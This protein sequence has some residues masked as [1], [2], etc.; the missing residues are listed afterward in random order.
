VPWLAIILIAVLVGLVVAIK[1]LPWWGI[2]ILFAVPIL[3]WKWIAGAIFAFYVRRVAGDLA[4]ALVGATVEVHSLKAVPAPDR[5]KLEALLAEHDDEEDKEFAESLK[6]AADQLPQELHWYEMEATI[7]PKFAP[8][9]GE[10]NPGWPPRSLMLIAP[11]GKWGT[12]DD[13]CLIASVEMEFQGR[14]QLATR[15]NAFG[16]ERVRLLF[17]VKPGTRKLIFHYLTENF[18][19]VIE[20]PPP[21][22]GAPASN[23]D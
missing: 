6:D 7:K 15:L 20:L 23:P 4:K 8:A 18:G 1:Y 13:V 9:E 10:D 5:D 12:I 3:T 19:D 2:V 22:D 21:L 14:M 17:G 11:G 16:E